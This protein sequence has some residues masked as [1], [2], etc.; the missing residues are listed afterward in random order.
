[1]NLKTFASLI[2]TMSIAASLAGVAA[3]A[4][5]DDNRDL[6]LGGILNHDH[7]HDHDGDNHGGNNHGPKSPRVVL[8]SLDGAKPDFIQKFIA[9]GVL[10]LDGGLAGLS[11]RGGWRCRT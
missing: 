4:R 5:A 1:M 7:D 8:I 11:L 6:G 9:E 3:P 10:P 2:S